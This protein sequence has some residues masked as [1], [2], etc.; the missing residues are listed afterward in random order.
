[1]KPRIR[2]DADVLT[3]T[4]ET[5]GD[6][7]TA[8]PLP[9]DSK[10]YVWVVDADHDSS[11]GQDP[12]IGNDFNVRI[13]I[14][15]SFIDGVVDVVGSIPGGGG[16]TV[17]VDG[18][19]IQITIDHSQIGATSPFNWLSDASRFLDGMGAGHGPTSLATATILLDSDGDCVL[20]AQDACPGFDDGLDADADSI[21]DGCDVCPGFD[22]AEPCPIPT[23]SEWGLVSITLLLLTTGTIL[24]R[25]RRTRA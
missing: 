4:I 16:G 12:I 20:D 24:L 21:P 2:Q 8:L 1:M 5:R 15:Q 6:I 18:N 10:T 25:S 7:P 17:S 22:D 19:T 13:T 23:V 14:G 9:D 11:T 3:F